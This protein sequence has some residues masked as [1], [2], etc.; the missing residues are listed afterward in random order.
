M[1]GFDNEIERAV[2]RAGKTSFGL[3]VVAV[4]LVVLTLLALSGLGNHGVSYIG[5]GE[6][7]LGLLAAAVF[8]ALATLIDLNGMQLIETWRQGRRS[9]T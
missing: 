4:V 9:D 5:F 8:H 3:K 2:N 7:L 6:A 1:D